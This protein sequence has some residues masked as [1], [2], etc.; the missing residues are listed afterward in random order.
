MFFRLYVLIHQNINIYNVLGVYSYNDAISM[1]NELSIKFP[2]NNYIIQ[3]PFNYNHNTVDPFCDPK[4]NPFSFPPIIEDPN[5]I[6][7]FG[8]PPQGNKSPPFLI[9]SINMKDPNRMDED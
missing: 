2:L 8:I 6:N 5:P 4:P 1:K 7:P 3:G 9:N